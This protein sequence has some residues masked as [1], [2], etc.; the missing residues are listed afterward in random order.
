MLSVEQGILSEILEFVMGTGLIPAD[1]EVWI[2]R[3]RAIV[4]SL[5][6][7]VPSFYPAVQQFSSGNSSH[8]RK[9]R[10]TYAVCCTSVVAALMH[11]SFHA[12]VPIQFVVKM[13]DTFGNAT[14]NLCNKLDKAAANGEDVE[15]EALFSRLTLDVIGKAVF[16]YEFDSLS[17]ET[18]IVEVLFRT[19]LLYFW[20]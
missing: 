14:Q 6:R 15:M 8:V 4:P 17:N 19:C 9:S 18:G 3:R 13:V 1:G 12:H 7:K 5:H 16:N 10:R 2:R 11:S 20:E